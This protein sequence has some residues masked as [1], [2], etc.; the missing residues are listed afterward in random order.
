MAVVDIRQFRANEWRLY[1]RLRLR[2]LADAPDA[3]GSTYE[4]A[5]ARPEQVWKSRL[6]EL[7]GHLD[8]ALLAEVDG[9]PAGLAWGRIEPDAQHTATVYQMWV[10]P[11]HRRS[12]AGR[13]L[14]DTVV[15]W[16]A[17]RGVT[18]VCLDVTIG[19]EPAERLYEAA[20]FRVC[21]PPA[22]LRPDSPLMERPMRLIV[23]V[24]GRP[25]AAR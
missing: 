14:L 13:R 19:N 17:G 25:G 4:A 5:A 18:S 6:A 16:A 21:G 9:A 20:G 11:E 12:G 24:A 23:A 10:A 7:D 8:A 1:R 15:A 2:A 3:F 22:P